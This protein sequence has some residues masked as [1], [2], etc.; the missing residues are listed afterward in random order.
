MPRMVAEDVAARLR[1]RIEAGEW[2]APGRLPP[3]RELA[4]DF[5]IAR[6]TLRRALGLLEEQGFLSRQLGRGN[7]VTRLESDS[8]SGILRRIKGSSPADLME[9][10]LLIEPAAAAAAATAAS[11]A[12]LGAIRQAHDSACQ[13][14]DMPAFEDWDAVFHQRVFDCT[15]NELLREMHNLL[16]LLRNQPLWFEMKR[17]AFSEDR[18]AVYCREH[19]A[20]LAALL[21]RDPE[22]A[23]QA[24]L[25]HL[26]T[27]RQN[28]LGW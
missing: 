10:R 16:R 27:V 20:L 15:R 9:V 28:L 19:A 7:Y 2:A 3:E 26:K 18:K 6:N 23:R 21:R 14:G 4:E 17:R 11:D 13:A 8:F 12:D 1:S 24:M 25:S 5:G 22:G